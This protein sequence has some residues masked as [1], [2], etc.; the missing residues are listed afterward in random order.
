[1]RINVL[2][3]IEVVADGGV[4]PLT[5]HGQ[6]ALLAALAFDQGKIVPADE[7]IGILWGENPPA[8][9]RT[10]IQSHVSALRRAIG[11]G[12]RD[13]DSPLLTIPP[14]YLL[15]ERAV[16]TDLAEFGALA[17]RGSRA[18][19]A[20]E[21]GIASTVFGDALALWRGTAFAGV[22]SAALRPAAKSLAERRLLVAEAKAEADL[23]LGRHGTVAGELSGWLISHP[24]RER[25][26][27]LTMLALHG[28]GC[29]AEALALYR[30]GQQ[31][32]TRE[33]GL[34]PGAWLRDLYQ[35]ILDD[36]PIQPSTATAA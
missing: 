16:E 14:G 35:R 30:A 19:E 21:L 33:L 1:M 7:L 11:Y 26:R 15:S 31:A 3:P 20:G 5:G 6:R 32:M 18:V 24:F 36:E 34:E 27:G 13:A 23:I 25:L 28:L 2:G 10:K 4:V 22:S 9:A 8:S 12:V 29:R 17:A